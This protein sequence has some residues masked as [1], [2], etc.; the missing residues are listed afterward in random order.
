MKPL[1]CLLLLS[2]LLAASAST[3]R[4]EPATRP[5]ETPLRVMS[6]NI[7][8]DNP[9]DGEHAWPKRR[10]LVRQV[11]S[12]YRPDVLGLQEALE[13]Q[14]KEIAG[15]LP[16]Y[17]WV[18]VG[19]DDGKAA[20][21][22]SPIVYNTRRLE[23]MESGTFWLSPTPEKVGSRGWDAALPRIATWAKFRDRQTGGEFVALNTH[24]D[25]RGEQARAESAKLIVMA[26][27]DEL[28]SIIG[29]VPVVITGDFNA[30]PDSEAYATLTG[31]LVDTR[32]A[33]E[34][35]LGPEG[36]FG[37]FTAEGEP[38]GR[39][40][41]VFVSNGVDVVRAGTLSP[42]WNGRHASDHFPVMADVTFPR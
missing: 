1:I 19:R 12:F 25:H 40:D 16:G 4:D 41:Y 15:D 38:G 17:A 29:E 39:I 5:V 27:D 2:M 33:V 31:A 30:T 3:A 26:L 34:T 36:T 42:H 28:A 22:F 9:G 23:V 37:T 24:F 6:F 32:T 18:G 10:P 13:H 11:L 20:G 21:E 8:Y 14:V 7:R 35:P